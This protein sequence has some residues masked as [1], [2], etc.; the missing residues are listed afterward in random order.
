MV[1]YVAMI[2]LA[3]LAGGVVGFLLGYA[4]AHRRRAS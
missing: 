1:E 3:A 2:V 4:V